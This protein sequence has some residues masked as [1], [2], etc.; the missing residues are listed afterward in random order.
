MSAVGEFDAVLA[1]SLVTFAPVHA[2]HKVQ[3]FC[4]W[5]VHEGLVCNQLY[6][7]QGPDMPAALALASRVVVPCEFSRRLYAPQRT[8]IDVIPYGVGRR[9]IRN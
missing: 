8:Q 1:N 9:A 7:D 2:A 6:A 4:I 3:K 5:Y